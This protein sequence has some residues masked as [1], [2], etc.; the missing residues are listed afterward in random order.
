M[1]T[2]RLNI[3]K[4]KSDK[5]VIT[6]LIKN[7]YTLP[8][9]LSGIKSAFLS[10]DETRFQRRYYKNGMHVGF[11][12]YMTDLTMGPIVE[13]NLAEALRKSCRVGNFS[14]RL[15]N[16]PNDQEKGVQRTP[17]DKIGLKDRIEGIKKNIIIRNQ[18]GSP[19][20]SGDS[21]AYHRQKAQASVTP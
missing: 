17:V 1:M 20:L 10:Q 21:V 4:I 18:S 9:Y 7:I 2:S 19:L 12:L 13:E 16:I 3:R 5:L 11:I 6:I 15:I 14:S 8:D